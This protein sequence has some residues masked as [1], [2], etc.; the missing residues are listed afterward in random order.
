[1]S[2]YRYPVRP[3]GQRVRDLALC[4]RLESSPCISGQGVCWLVSRWRTSARGRLA[5]RAPVEWRAD[6]N[7]AQQDRPGSRYSMRSATTH[8]R[9][10][11]TLAHRSIFSRPSDRQHVASRRSSH[12]PGRPAPRTAGPLWASRS[13]AGELDELWKLIPSP[14]RRL[15]ANDL[16]FST[17]GEGRSDP[18]KLREYIT[19]HSGEAFEA[20]RAVAIAAPVAMSSV[21]ALCTQRDPPGAPRAKYLQMDPQTP[22]YK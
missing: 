21:A 11:S 14:G 16:M 5:N 22:R 6:A 17:D 4:D 13:A 19:E 1:M 12:A 9:G 18:S 7:T 8:C 2:Q 20:L 10:A 3:G 15:A